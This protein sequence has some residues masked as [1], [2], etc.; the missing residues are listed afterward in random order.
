MFV[1]CV[2]VFRKG[3][4]GQIRSWLKDERLTPPAEETA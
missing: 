1:A 3:I 2:M 4:V